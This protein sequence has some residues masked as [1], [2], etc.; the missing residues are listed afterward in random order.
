MGRRVSGLAAA[1]VQAAHWWPLLTPALT[2]CGA[3]F[4]SCHAQGLEKQV[5]E[6]SDHALASRMEYLGPAAPSATSLL[7]AAPPYLSCSCKALAQ[8]LSIRL[9]PRYQQVDVLC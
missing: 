1:Q 6:R 7:T 5:C 8:K 3:H 2:Y 4:A 9:G